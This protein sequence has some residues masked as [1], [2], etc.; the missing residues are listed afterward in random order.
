MI[1]ITRL[2][3][4]KESLSREG[5]KKMDIFTKTKRNMIDYGKGLTFKGDVS[6]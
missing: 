6:R 5:K 2:Y 4:F 3:R 1:I